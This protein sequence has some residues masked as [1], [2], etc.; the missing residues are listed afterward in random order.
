MPND[1]TRAQKIG[2]TSPDATW[3]KNQ[4]ISWVKDK[5]FNKNAKIYEFLDYNTSVNLLNDHIEGKEN[6]RL[7]IWSL[8]NLDEYLRQYA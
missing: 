1:I 8:L 7:F 2:F 4:S 6:R 3:F 5:L